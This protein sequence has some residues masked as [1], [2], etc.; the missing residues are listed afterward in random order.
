MNGEPEAAGPGTP[1]PRLT[2]PRLVL[3]R[4]KDADRVPLAAINADPKVS[5]YLPSPLTREES[6]AFL[7]RSE[8]HFVAHGFGLWA[9]EYAVVG[10]ADEGVLAGC[11]GLNVPGFEAHFTPCV[12][13]GWRLAPMFWGRGLAVEAAQA[14]LEFGFDRIGLEEIVAFTVPGNTRSRTVMERLGMTHDPSD[15]FEHPSLPDCHPLRSH[16]LYRLRRP[17]P[18][19]R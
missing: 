9:V 2:T 13:I 10:D 4:W 17:Q 11:V 1:G 5:E 7:D 3:R 8:A 16:V 14:A 19:R 18:D 15:D 12:E 6:D